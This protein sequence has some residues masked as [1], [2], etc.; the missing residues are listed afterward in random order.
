MPSAQRAR[1][2]GE[3][4]LLGMGLTLLAATALLAARAQPA[5]A[6]APVIAVDANVLSGGV[7]PNGVYTPTDNE[8]WIQIAIV[9]AAPTGGFEF[10]LSYD[11]Q[12]FQY[13]GWSEGPFLRSTGLTTAC[14]PGISQ[15]AV[16]IG[17]GTIGS[18]GDAGPS[19]NGTL[20]VLRF[21]PKLAARACFLL[22][23]VETATTD[24]VPIPTSSQDGCVTPSTLTA[25]PTPTRTA[26]SAPPA[27]TTTAT[28]TS[29]PPAATATSVPPPTATPTSP[30]AQ[31][32]LPTSTAAPPPAP[33]SAPAGPQ[34][35]GVA[36]GHASVR[37]SP[38]SDRPLTEPGGTLA[39]I[40][41]PAIGGAAP[42]G[43]ALAGAGAVTP[44]GGGRA[45]DSP[46][47]MGVPGA[48]PVSDAS[49]QASSSGGASSS[50]Q[51]LG[52][53]LHGDDARRDINVTAGS[54]GAGGFAWWTLAVAIIGGCAAVGAG[55]AAARWWRVRR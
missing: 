37:G 18:S 15:H 40:A 1:V 28:P 35:T 39:P 27:F 17:C 11:A 43:G 4:G 14:V 23:G 32:A 54:S 30:P 41:G 52:T 9:D 20:I 3:R 47:G 26:T 22:A 29:M 8:V 53:T 31:S 13:L 38:S 2:L 12:I 46:Q 49:D 48:S 6:V 42:G 55:G 36:T 25:P 19:G 24:G 10:E 34:P 21:H 5:L 33:T 51:V 16:R 7:Q 45:T 44:S 50:G